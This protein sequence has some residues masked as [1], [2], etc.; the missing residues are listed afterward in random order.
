M[1]NGKFS[2]SILTQNH[3]ENYIFEFNIAH[4]CNKISIYLFDFEKGD[5][6]IGLINFSWIFFVI[7][8]QK[9]RFTD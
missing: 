8:L 3:F 2:K 1:L 6:A 5:F 4:F 7:N 9:F